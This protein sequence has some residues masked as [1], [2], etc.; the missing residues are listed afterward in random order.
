MQ[1][2]PAGAR[3]FTAQVP[4]G[5]T[6]RFPL[7]AGNYSTTTG[8]R[9]APPPTPISRCLAA[10]PSAAKAERGQALGF[11]GIEIGGTGS[12]TVFQAISTTTLLELVSPSARQWPCAIGKSPS[13][14]FPLTANA[15][16][17]LSAGRPL[18]DRES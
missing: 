1:R 3:R 18:M 12:A 17:T 9:A 13:G 16:N 5:A 7:D 10:G 11:G 14:T 15:G 6:N 8:A 2:E 4:A